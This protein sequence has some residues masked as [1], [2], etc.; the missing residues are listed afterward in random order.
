MRWKRGFRKIGTAMWDKTGGN[1]VL[2]MNEKIQVMQGG[3]VEVTS[4]THVNLPSG[5][6]Q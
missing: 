6:T 1:A 3:T 2:K 4:T 5:V